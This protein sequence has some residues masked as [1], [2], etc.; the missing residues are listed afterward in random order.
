MARDREPCAIDGP[1]LP[2]LDLAAGPGVF[3]QR[4][5]EAAQQ[6]ADVGAADVAG[7]PQRLD[8]AVGNGVGELVGE[9]VETGR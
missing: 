6:A 7:E 1:A 4:L 9:P 3:T 8:D 2:G 5:T